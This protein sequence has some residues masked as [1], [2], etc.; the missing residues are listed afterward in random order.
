M[1][2]SLAHTT[3]IVLDI[4]NTSRQALQAPNAMESSVIKCKRAN[5][6]NKLQHKQIIS[7]IMLHTHIK[8][9]NDYGLRKGTVLLV[10]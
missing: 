8:H 2:Y 10:A 4:L 1:L 6:T 3:I 7:T 9:C 5:R